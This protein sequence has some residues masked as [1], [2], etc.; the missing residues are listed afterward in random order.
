[1]GGLEVDPPLPPLYRKP[2]G[3]FA[4]PMH[5]ASDR[6]KLAVWQSVN[7]ESE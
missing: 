4:T 2:D 6:S 7:T 1:M 3:C 5:A